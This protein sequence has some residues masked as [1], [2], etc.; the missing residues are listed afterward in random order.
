[1]NLLKYYDSCTE[2]STCILDLTKLDFIQENSQDERHVL[3]NHEQQSWTRIMNKNQ[4][5]KY[6]VIKGFA[7][8]SGFLIL[9]LCN[10]MS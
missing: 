1:M 6:K 10:P 8:S 9:Y 5:R 7:I 2:I 3:L 4:R